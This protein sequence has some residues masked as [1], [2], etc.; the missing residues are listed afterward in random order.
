MRSTAFLAAAA[1]AAAAAGSAPPRC[2]EAL[3]SFWSLKESSKCGCKTCHF[4]IKR[5]NTTLHIFSPMHRYA[6]TVRSNR[7]S[8]SSMIRS[9][10]AE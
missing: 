2:L 7:Q 4:F 8:N 10:V 6:C 3:S 9:F 1:A 5:V